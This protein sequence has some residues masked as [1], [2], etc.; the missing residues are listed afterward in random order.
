MSDE[1]VRI[2]GDEI[3]WIRVTEH[4]GEYD[5]NIQVP[6]QEMSIPVDPEFYQAVRSLVDEP[7]GVG[8]IERE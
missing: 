6:G 5:L 1:T 2:D 8:R 4:N 3:D 7:T